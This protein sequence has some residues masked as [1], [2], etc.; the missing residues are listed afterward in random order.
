MTAARDGVE[1][2]RRLGTRER[3]RREKQRRVADAAEVVFRRLGYDRATVRA[4]AAHAGVSVGTVFEFAPD[5]RTL[6]L[7]IFGPMLNRLTDRAI[8]SLDR[9][10]SLLDQFVHIF[11]ERYRFFHDDIDLARHLVSDLSFFPR[12]SEPEGAVA[13]YLATRSELRRKIADVVIEQQRAGRVDASVDARDVVSIAM[14]IN[15]IEVREWLAEE[16]P[17]L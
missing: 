2:L 5:K 13:D 3:G 10:A 14:N 8:A 1:P 15:L 9:N 12:A 7:L 17:E 11:R 16:Q 6:L 4:I